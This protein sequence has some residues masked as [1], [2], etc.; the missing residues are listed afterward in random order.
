M[1]DGWTVSDEAINNMDS[2]AGQ[3]D[4]CQNNLKAILATLKSD[5]DDNEG[6]LGAHSDSIKA[7][8]EELEGLIGD[9]SQKVLKLVLKLRKSAG[10]RKSHIDTNNYS[11]GKTR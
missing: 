9:S 10:I 5:F 4:E 1:G 7:L 2:L 11:K 8:I 6:G 3:L